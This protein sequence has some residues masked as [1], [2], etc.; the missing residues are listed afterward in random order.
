MIEPERST[1]PG[2][3]ASK[4]ILSS[5][6][7]VARAAVNT[8]LGCHEAYHTGTTARTGRGLRECFAALTE[9]CCL[10]GERLGDGQS[11]PKAAS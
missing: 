7:E 6:N 11:D 8:A 1:I 3:P 4:E 2:A 5:L 9:S 10:D